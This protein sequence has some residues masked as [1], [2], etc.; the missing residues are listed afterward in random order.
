MRSFKIPAGIML[1]ML[2][3]TGLAVK[4]PLAASSSSGSASAYVED[5]LLSF[6]Q[7]FSTL[8]FNTTAIQPC[9]DCGSGPF[10]SVVGLWNSGH[11]DEFGLAWN[12]HTFLN[13]ISASHGFQAIYDVYCTNRPGFRA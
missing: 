8:A 9:G 11:L 2:A 10:Y 6:Q 5:L 13:P 3:F 12:W 4:L 7:N 1:T